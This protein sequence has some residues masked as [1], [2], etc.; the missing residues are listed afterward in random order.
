MKTILG[1]LLM[2]IA[3]SAGQPCY[4]GI[5]L[6]LYG[7]YK[8]G[9]LL[10]V[11][12]VAMG[13]FFVWALDA[14]NKAFLGERTQHV[15]D[16]LKQVRFIENGNL[17]RTRPVKT[18]TKVWND[19]K[20]EMMLGIFACSLMSV[21]RIFYELRQ[22]SY[23]NILFWLVVTLIFVFIVELYLVI[24]FSKKG[25]TE[26]AFRNK[27]REKETDWKYMGYATW[28]E[29]SVVIM[30]ETIMKCYRKY[31]Y[32]CIVSMLSYCLLIQCWFTVPQYRAVATVG[33]VV[34]WWISTYI[35]REL[36]QKSREIVI[37]ILNGDYAKSMVGFFIEYYKLKD[38]KHCSLPNTAQ[39]DL[40]VALDTQ[41]AWRDVLEVNKVIIF[42]E[43]SYEE[44]VH[45]MYNWSAYE[46][47]RH[48]EKCV[49]TF[50][51]MDF[52]MDTLRL[53]TKQRNF[54][55]CRAMTTKN[56]D[57]A[58]ALLEEVKNTSY[59]MNTWKNRLM[60]DAKEQIW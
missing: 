35:N 49:E 5:K 1:F 43:G 31:Y 19:K 34:M 14:F 59:R 44:Y 6:F 41:G 20:R 2:V 21:S 36:I 12:A 51:R 42:E 48:Y 24:Q 40:V 32:Q 4:L 60:Q 52:I 54:R 8:Q 46:G 56:Y 25:M 57:E 22:D 50:N 29:V 18:A 13:I 27:I 26:L 30:E 39:T 28:D 33:Y 53:N 15:K 16:V 3:L 38:R 11:S 10:L 55:I 17:M 37:S 9:S 58:L 45:C 23:Y 47:L 7:D